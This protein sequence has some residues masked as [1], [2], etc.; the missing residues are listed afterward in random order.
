MVVA[1]F[2]Y[3]LYAVLLQRLPHGI[4]LSTSVFL[5]A[6][7]GSVLLLPAYIAETVIVGPVPFTGEVVAATLGLAVLASVVSIYMWNAS[8]R[9]VGPNRAAVFVNLLPAYGAMLAIPVLGEE[10]FAYHVAGFAVVVAGILM[11][12]RGHR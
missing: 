9:A 7:F 12:I 4:G 6:T 11:V 3:A 2:S 10:L 8:N 5:I 1:T